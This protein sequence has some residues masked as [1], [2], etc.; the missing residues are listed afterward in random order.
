MVGLHTHTL[1]VRAVY[2]FTR[3]G[4]TGTTGTANGKAVVMFKYGRERNAWDAI[5]LG[6]GVHLPYVLVPCRL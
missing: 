4:S 5:I 3:E 6:E 1:G 2:P